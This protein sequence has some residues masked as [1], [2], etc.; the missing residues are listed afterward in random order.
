MDEV[1]SSLMQLTKHD[2]LFVST[3]AKS[4]QHIQ[5]FLINKIISVSIPIYSCIG[6]RFLSKER[7]K[8]ESKESSHLE[9]KYLNKTERHVTKQQ[10]TAHNSYFALVLIQLL[11]NI[12]CC[13]NAFQTWEEIMKKCDALSFIIAYEFQYQQYQHFKFCQLVNNFLHQL[14]G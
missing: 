12:L 13:Y 8:R 14:V 1:S 5:V 4:C 10:S 7:T 3:E 11:L 6:D 9:G 2:E